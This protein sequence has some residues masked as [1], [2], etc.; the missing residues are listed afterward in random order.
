M[1]P[2]IAAFGLRLARN[3]Y[4]IADP[5]SMVRHGGAKGNAPTVN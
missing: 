2:T 3:N 5:L 1:E 4:K